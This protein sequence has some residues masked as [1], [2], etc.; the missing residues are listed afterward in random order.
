MERQSGILRQIGPDWAIVAV[1]PASAG[2]GACS[3]RGGCGIGRLA[4]HGGGGSGT[5]VEVRID[6]DPEMPVHAGLSIGDTVG[7]AIDTEALLPAAL[8]GYLLPA[9]LL[10]AGA[11]IGE[12]AGSE[13]TAVIGALTGLAVGIAVPRV[14]TP[15]LPRTR[16]RLAETSDSQ[17][18]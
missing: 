14:L 11:A 5:D 13:G 16:L 2:C 4:R 18:R 10:I 15:L 9:T 6:I 7:V 1:D 8:L 3:Q 17:G 12:H